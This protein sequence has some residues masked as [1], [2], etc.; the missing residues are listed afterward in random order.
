[1]SV[2]T[3]SQFAL[4]VSRGQN[5]CLYSAGTLNKVVYKVNLPTS[6]GQG[7]FPFDTILSPA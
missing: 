6:Y 3:G 2:K 1:M 4:K 5:S 7:V